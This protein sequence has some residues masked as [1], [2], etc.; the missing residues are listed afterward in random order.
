M[1]TTII[2]IILMLIVIYILYKDIIVIWL[3]VYLAILYS[4]DDC[5]WGE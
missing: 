3:I 1:M 2:N 5:K 4:K